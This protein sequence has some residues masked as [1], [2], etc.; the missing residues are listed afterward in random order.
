[1]GRITFRRLENIEYIGISNECKKGGKA[2]FNNNVF[3]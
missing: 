2:V 1:M 3:L